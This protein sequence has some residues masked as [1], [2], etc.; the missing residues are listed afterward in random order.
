VT[1]GP[2]AHRKV[3][4]QIAKGLP[5]E[6]AIGQVTG[7]MFTDTEKDFRLWLGAKD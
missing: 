3:W 7:K 5:I 6:Q 4:A 2:D 1:Y